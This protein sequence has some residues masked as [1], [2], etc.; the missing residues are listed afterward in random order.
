MEGSLTEKTNKTQLERFK[1]AARELE[2]D[3][4]KARFEKRLKKLVK[5]KPKDGDKDK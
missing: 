3:D 1:D 5:Q 4:D 2:V